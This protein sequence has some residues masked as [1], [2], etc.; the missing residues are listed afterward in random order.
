M[1]RRIF[2]NFKRWAGLPVVRPLILFFGVFGPATITAMADNDAGGVATY[3]VA[4]ATLGYPIL[5]VLLII[6]VLLGVTQEMGMRLTLITRRGLADLIRE[7]FGI[8][9]SLVI[10]GAL[11][12]ANLGTLTVELAA[13]KVTS[14]ML[15]LPA[16]PFIFLIVIIAGVVVTKGNYKLTQGIMLITSLFYLAYIISA[17]K[18]KPNWGLAISNIFWPNGVDFT[19]QYMR[20]YLLIGMGVLGTTITPWGQFFIS[21]FAYDKNIEAGKIIYSQ[22]ETYVGAFLTD[23][24]SFFMIVATAATLFVNKIPLQSGEAAALAIKP[25]AG[26]LAGTLFALGILNAAFMGLIVVS[27]STAYAFA[28]FFGLSGSLDSN[29]KQSKSFYLIFI[30]Q[31]V[32]ATLFVMIPGVSLFKLAIITQTINAIAL[33]L[34][35]YYLIKLANDKGLMG[36]YVNNGFQKW[37]TIAGSVAIFGASVLTLGATFFPNIGK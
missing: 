33:P 20:N 26:E 25:F 6:T 11:L 37:F 17:V 18:A 16:I 9:V 24:F 32:F 3:S 7:K 15:N 27:L 35:F 23:F 19:P 5:F 36:K 4:G 31:L 1:R 30:I 28:E 2:F 10:F 8:K 34:V 22:L 21:S 12:I 13:V 29:Y 14:G